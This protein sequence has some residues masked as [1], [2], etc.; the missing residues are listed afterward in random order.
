[1][2]TVTIKGKKFVQVKLTNSKEEATRIAAG[3]RKQH[4]KGTA[5]SK[6]FGGYGLYAVY[7]LQ[8]TTPKTEVPAMPTT[9][10]QTTT[11]HHGAPIGQGGRADVAMK[12]LVRLQRIE[13]EIKTLKGHTSARTQALM[14]G[15]PKGFKTLEAFAAHM[16]KMVDAE[17]RKAQGLNQVQYRDAMKTLVRLQR[18]E[19]EIKTLKGRTSAREQT[20]MAGMP[21]GFKTLK[22]VAAHM[23]KMVDA[24]RRKAQ[25]LNQVQYRDAM[26]AAKVKALLSLKF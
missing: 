19:A 3:I 15:M 16:D 4:G 25:G 26:E 2:T 21:K 13:A 1:M 5:T 23:G 17:R 9:T 8:S 6:K 24:E 12:T 18:I 11:T 7:Q 10:R 14:A 20:L 22:S